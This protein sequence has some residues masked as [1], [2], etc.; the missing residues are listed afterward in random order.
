[1]IKLI[2]ADDHQ[3]FIDGVSSVLKKYED[4]EIVETANNGY[5]VLDILERQ[6]IDVVLL[7]IEMPKLDGVETIKLIKQNY[8]SVRVIMVSMYN[9]KEFVSQSR[10]YGALGYILKESSES[11]LL[12]AVR[13]VYSG[14]RYYEL[15][16]EDTIDSCMSK[17]EEE[18]SI[19]SDREV[20]VMCKLAE[21]HTA[22]E[23]GA[24][25]FISKATVDTHRRN[26]FTKLGIN[27]IVQLTRYAIKHGYVKL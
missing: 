9:T 17:P 12:T 20:D 24:L 25:L 8:P 1:M 23:A 19:L 22:K 2:I 14:G 3:M 27:N 15:K 16:V 10:K 21:S 7:D 4:I 26:I 11:I 13:T 5:Q 18:V 6:L